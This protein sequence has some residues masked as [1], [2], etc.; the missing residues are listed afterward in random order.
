MYIFMSVYVCTHG[1]AQTPVYQRLKEGHGRFHRIQKQNGVTNLLPV[2]STLFSKQLYY[3][4]TFLFR[5]LCF[6]ICSLCR[7]EMA[8][9]TALKYIFSLIGFFSIMVPKPQGRVLIGQVW[10][11]YKSLQ[12]SKHSQGCRVTAPLRSC[13]VCFWRKIKLFQ[14][15]PTHY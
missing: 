15:R 5:S 6:T 4:L 3:F 7:W 1:H 12:M 13:G 10:I 9:P 2:I 11:K 8:H 14:T